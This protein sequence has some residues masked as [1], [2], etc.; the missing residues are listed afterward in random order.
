VVLLPGEIK[1]VR[2]ALAMF[3]GYQLHPDK[4]YHDG[5]A[6]LAL[7]GRTDKDNG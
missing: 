5:E 4:T 7:L 2:Q 6:A 3:V 1:Q